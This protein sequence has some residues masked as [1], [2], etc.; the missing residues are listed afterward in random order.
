MFL[1]LSPPCLVKIS[2]RCSSNC[3]LLVLSKYQLD[4]SAR[5]LLSPGIQN[6]ILAISWDPKFNH[7]RLHNT[8]CPSGSEIQSLQVATEKCDGCMG[9]CAGCQIEKSCQGDLQLLPTE[10]HHSRRDGMGRRRGRRVQQLKPITAD[11][12]RWDIGGEGEFNNSN[13]SQQTR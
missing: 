4:Q 8:C 5:Y 1:K 3:L 7:C 2:T 11:E 6:S 13:P 12:M 10:T 9:G